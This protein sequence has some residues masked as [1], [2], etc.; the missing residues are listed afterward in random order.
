MRSRSIIEITREERPISIDRLEQIDSLIWSDGK[1]THEELW[2]L[3]GTIYDAI[4][5]AA[6]DREWTVYR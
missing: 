2:V 5:D 3:Y 1:V 4:G 6:L